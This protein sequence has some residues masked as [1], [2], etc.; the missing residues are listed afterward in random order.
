MMRVHLSPSRI[1]FVRER[2]KEVI[3]LSVSL[4]VLD[5]EVSLRLN[6]LFRLAV[7]YNALILLLIKIIGYYWDIEL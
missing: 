1:Y 5:I 2:A 7:C 3:Q 6:I 4:Y